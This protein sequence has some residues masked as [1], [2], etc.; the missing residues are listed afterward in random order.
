MSGWLI[1]LTGAIYAYVAAEQLYRGNHGL[2]IAY[3]GYRSPTLAST[4]SPESDA[5]P[6]PDLSPTA[7]AW[8]QA[9][10]GELHEAE[11]DV[12][13]VP[14]EHADCGGSKVGGYFSAD[15]GEFV[16]ATGGDAALSLS[17]FIHEYCHFRQSQADTP[18]WIAT[19]PG[20]CCPQQA[21]DA[22]LA[23]VVEMTPNQLRRAVGMVLEMEHECETIALNLLAKTPDLPLDREW[24]IRAANVYLGWYGVVMRTRRWYDRS[25]Y[26]SPEP[27]RIMP[28]DRLLTVDEAMEPSPEFDA[29]IRQTCYVDAAAA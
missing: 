20:G 3:T 25:P 11:I 16:V 28:G 8:L 14:T 23:G 6:F 26:S 17:V 19:L 7:N 9:A 1:A 15:A 27:L 21:F 5:M 4:R 13:L 24:Y 18:A 10:I 2:A 29:A 22:W 12:R